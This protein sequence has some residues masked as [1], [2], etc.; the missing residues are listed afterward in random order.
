MK[1]SYLGGILLLL[2]IFM[3]GCRNTT[4]PASESGGITE[5]GTE[6]A[7]EPAIGTDSASDIYSIYVPKEMPEHDIA[8][9]DTCLTYMNGETYLQVHTYDEHNSLLSE[10]KSNAETGEQ[11]SIANYAYIYNEQ[12]LV[13]IKYWNSP[14][15]YDV[16]LYNELGLLTESYSIWNGSESDHYYYEYDEHGNET[17]KIR[18]MD[19]E[20][21][22]ASYTEYEYDEEGNI[23]VYKN[24]DKDKA[25]SFTIY[26]E[27]N[28]DNRVI[29]QRTEFENQG[30]YNYSETY[31]YDEH[32]NIIR[33]NTF[34]ADSTEPAS[35]TLYEYDEKNRCTKEERFI[36]GE[37]YQK[38]V[39]EYEDY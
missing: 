23:S 9:K 24:Y 36:D 21:K 35:Y 16:F 38:E 3:A 10:E 4:I 17:S 29:E 39:H 32:G 1:K 20:I 6:E 7:E 37:S 15:S 30:I 22:D 5:P 13:E 27:Y 26:R 25:L 33:S 31:E 34:F 19:G 11:E 28:E 18:T 2:C 14:D 8:Y 12:D